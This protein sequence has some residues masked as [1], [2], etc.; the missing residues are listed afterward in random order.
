MNSSIS[1]E[2]FCNTCINSKLAALKRERDQKE[3]EA[4]IKAEQDELEYSRRMAELELLALNESR[5]QLKSQGQAISKELDDRF[6]QKRA[7]KPVEPLPDYQDNYTKELEESRAKYRQELLDQI[8][9]KKSIRSKERQEEIN[10]EK[11]KLDDLEAEKNRTLKE[12]A[13]E[14]LM[15]RERYKYTLNQQVN[16]KNSRKVEEDY[17]KKV[18]KVI[19]DE[20]VKRFQ[21]EQRMLVSMMK[22]GISPNSPDVSQI[23]F[24][25]DCSECNDGNFSTCSN[26]RKLL[27][28]QALSKFP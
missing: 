23:G 16:L 21:E 4:R 9:S 27:P 6:Q 25:S 26:C 22:K 8:E 13:Y 20:Q 14:S 2:L 24:R 17:Q 10:N 1:N 7:R 5:Q 15:Q 3:R 12:L 18:E 19:L 28:V 11:K